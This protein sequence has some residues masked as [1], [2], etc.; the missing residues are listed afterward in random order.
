LTVTEEG[1]ARTGRRGV[2][3]R[4]SSNARAGKEQPILNRGSVGFA[5][6]AESGGEAG[7]KTKKKK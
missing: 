3:V 4:N 1:S 2:F 7:K 5:D 6:A